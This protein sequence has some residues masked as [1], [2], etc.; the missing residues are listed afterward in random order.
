[1]A[2]GTGEEIVTWLRGVPDNDRAI[3]IAFPNEASYRVYGPIFWHVAH[4]LPEIVERVQRRRFE[5]L[6]DALTQLLVAQ[7]GAVPAAVSDA[8]V[9]PAKRALPGC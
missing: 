2:T 3:L 4:K 6:V 1:M 7:P 5:K 9:T 8:G